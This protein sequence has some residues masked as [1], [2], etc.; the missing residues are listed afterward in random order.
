MCKSGT[1]EIEGCNMTCVD[2][3]SKIGN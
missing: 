2:S 3:S 1:V